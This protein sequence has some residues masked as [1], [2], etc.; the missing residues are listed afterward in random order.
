[1]LHHFANNLPCRLLFAT[2]YHL[3]TDEFKYHPTVLLA[4][5][6]TTLDD[7]TGELT[8]LY[9]LEPGVC[10][11]SYGMKVAELAGISVKVTCE[12]VKSNSIR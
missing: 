1:M 2:H 12:D 5:M 7:N 8:F 6:A 11:K 9:K 4:Q 3:L 10:P